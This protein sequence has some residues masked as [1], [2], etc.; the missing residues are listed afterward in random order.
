MGETQ[1]RLYD[2]GIFAKVDMAIQNPEGD[3][4]HRFVLYDM[5]EA[6]RWT[7]T[8]GLGA[9]IARIGGSSAAN[10]LSNPGGATGFSPNVE[11]DATR[12]NFLGRGQTLAL[13]TRYSNIDKRGQLT[14]LIPRF[15][16][17][18]QRDLTITTLYDNSYDVR[19]FASKREEASVQLTDRW[20]K[21]TTVFYRL[22]YRNVNVSNL[23]IN[24]LLIP[25]F[26]SATRTGLAAV[27][28]V[29]DRRDDPT[30]AHRG[31]YTSVDV[32]IASHLLGG[33]NSFIRFLGR[34]ATY[35]RIGEKYIFARQTSFGVLPTYGKAA[36][37]SPED[38]DP[39]PLAERFFG[40]GTDSLRA[41]PQN[42]AGPRDSVTGFPL[43]GSAL[44]FN[45][46]E[47]RFPLI[48]DNIGGVL[49]EDF[50]NV[51]STPADISFS[52]HQPHPTIP[53]ISITWFMRPD[54]ASAI[55]RPSVPS[56]W[57]WR[58]ASIRP[59]TTALPEHFQQ[60]V[61]C[62]LRP[63]TASA[64][65]SRSVI[66]SSSSPSGRH[67]DM[68]SL[69]LSFFVVVAGLKAVLID[70]IAITVGNQAITESEIERE[71]RLSSLLNGAAPDTGLEARREAA[72]RLIEQA[73][74]RREMSFGSYPPVPAA[75][76]DEALASTR[77]SH[78]GQPGFAALLAKYGLT[79]KDLR[80]YLT[81]QLALLKFIDLRFR[82]AVQVTE[83]DVETYYKQHSSAQPGPD[84]TTPSLH[85]LHDQIE[86][87]L[88]GERVDTQLDEWMKRSEER[89]VIRYLDPKL[90]KPSAAAL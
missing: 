58:T 6:S 45:N 61:H 62:R 7:I 11:L 70:E 82:P 88:T 49:F 25:L 47:L 30:D 41:V 31:I 39:I 16:N 24:P 40:G 64:A 55:E 21:A 86:Q 81:W 80:D 3:A 23:K 78:G 60:L 53:R 35:T 66:F 18:P 54:S 27:N 85:D 65:C 22:S 87:K 72:D 79:E 68:R 52:F 69:L 76:V 90:A 84:G 29:N 17:Y 13:R 67:S 34:N 43:G 71:I 63:R 44:F 8:G 28:V 14:Y 9:Q 19:T 56:V 51:F 2:L 1:R 77:K 50:G 73:L 59:S 38:P 5:E 89:T 33:R 75:Q 4:S 46:S 48:G 20:S 26:S 74:V 83:E 57:T 37:T 12:I 36:V 42:Q 32:G 10:D 15:R